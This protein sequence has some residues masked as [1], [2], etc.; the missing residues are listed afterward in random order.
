MNNIFVCNF[1]NKDWHN[2][3][4]LSPIWRDLTKWEK[5]IIIYDEN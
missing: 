5:V 4:C 1:F 3:Y 2:F